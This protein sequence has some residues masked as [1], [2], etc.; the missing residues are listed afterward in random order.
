MAKKGRHRRG[1]HLIELIAIVA[2]LTAIIFSLGKSFVHRRDESR[3]TITKVKIRVL[4][5]ALTNFKRDNGFYPST[6]QGLSALIEKPKN[7]RKPLNYPTAGYLTDM[8]L[9]EDGF[10]CKWSYYS[11]GISGHDFEIVSLGKGCSIGGEGVDA[12]I[13]SWQVP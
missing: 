8:D 1:I 11:P 12:D 6:G 10:R 13:S 5:S 2:V 9:L 7:G 4:R 3:A